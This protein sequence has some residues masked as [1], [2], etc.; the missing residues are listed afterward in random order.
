[1]LKH[2]K[3][4]VKVYANL[5]FLECLDKV[6]I[7]VSRLDLQSI[8]AE[9]RQRSRNE[10][11]KSKSEHMHIRQWDNLRHLTMRRHQN[12]R[13]QFNAQHEF[14]FLFSSPTVRCK[15]RGEID[16]EKAP[17][18]SA[19]FVRCRQTTKHKI[20]YERNLVR[21]PSGAVL[22]EVNPASSSCYFAI[23]PQ[24]N[25][26]DGPMTENLPRWRR[27]TIAR[28]LREMLLRFILISIRCSFRHSQPAS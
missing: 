19:P 11:K 2:S 24:V 26:P 22:S 15:K 1:M 25:R 14:F 7:S 16:S 3:T 4:I 21:P 18:S 12:N 13:L 10:R 8:I 17:I 23:K 27:N 9:S 20:H 5:E 28:Q 6:T